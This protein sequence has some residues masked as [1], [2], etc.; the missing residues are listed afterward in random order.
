MADSYS[1]R[2]I[3]EEEQIDLLI[4]TNQNLSAAF[5]TYADYKSERGFI[6]E[7]IT[8]QDIYS[9]FSGFDKQDKIRNCI[10]YYFENHG[11]MYVILGGD[12]DPQIRII[13]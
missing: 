11:L 3:S 12:S 6:T 13:I 5:Q 9:T 4:I 1:F 7:I 10:K 2:N 8:T